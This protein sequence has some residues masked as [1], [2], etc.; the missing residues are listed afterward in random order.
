[1]AVS[2]ASSSDAGPCWFEIEVLGPLVSVIG[3][4][5]SVAGGI[6]PM[7]LQERGVVVM[8]IVLRRPCLS[9]IREVPE[10]LTCS[11]CAVAAP[12]FSNAFASSGVYLLLVECFLCSDYPLSILLFYSK[13]TVFILLRH[14]HS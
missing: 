9:V 14:I 11:M 3:Q 4:E 7:C 6:V 10:S 5:R 1:M 12:E 13:S 8:R 2:H